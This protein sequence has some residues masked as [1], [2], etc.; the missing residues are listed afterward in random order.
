MIRFAEAFSLV[1]MMSLVLICGPSPAGAQTYLPAI[2]GSLDDTARIE[3]ALDACNSK[4]AKC[5]IELG[6]GDFWVGPIVVY[7]FHGKFFGAGAGKTV[8]RAIPS[9]PVSFNFL[10]P[11]SKTNRYPQLFTFLSGDF[12][13]SDM[14][15]RVEAYQPFQAYQWLDFLPPSNFNNGILCITQKPGSPAPNVVVEHV[16]LSGAD[17]DAAPWYGYILPPGS[18]VNT[19]NAVFFG[20]MFLRPAMDGGS[21]VVRNSEFKRLLTA[22]FTLKVVGARINVTGNSVTESLDALGVNL[23][24]GSDIKMMENELGAWEYGLR[25]LQSPYFDL[26][27]WGPA[28]ASK[29]MIS[30]NKVNVSQIADFP[31]AGI[32]LRDDYAQIGAET[33][34]LDALVSQNRVAMSGIAATAPR[35]GI[36]LMTTDST[37]APNNTV[38]VSGTAALAVNGATN[39]QILSP[40]LLSFTATQAQLWLSSA[41][42]GCLVSGLPAGLSVLNEG[43][44]NKLLGPWKH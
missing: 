25:I 6:P 13:I 38:T 20:A 4:A 18:G 17:G 34:R 36:H 43:T 16:E 21:L 31:V 41:S 12:T 24:S 30:H 26:E 1:G 40:D 15:V 8:I 33:P 27:G 11:I 3:Q 22:V 35:H 14:S 42:S 32:E 2:P 9:L 28:K 19:N 10:E 5:T 29:Y 37:N 39:C 7:D 44:N 23:A